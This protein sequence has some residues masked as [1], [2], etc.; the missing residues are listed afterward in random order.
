MTVTY[1]SEVTVDGVTYVPAGALATY[2]CAADPTYATIA[3]DSGS[4]ILSVSVTILC[5]A[6]VK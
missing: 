2:T 4:S 3:I 5:G 6:N 1:S